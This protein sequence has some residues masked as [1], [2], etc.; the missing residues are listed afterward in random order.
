MLSLSLPLLGLLRLCFLAVVG[1]FCVVL[2]KSA[3]ADPSCGLEDWLTSLNASANSYVAALGSAS[4]HEAARQ[5]R[6]EMERYDRDRLL[7]QIRDSDLGQNE[8]ALMNYISS[9]RHL[10]DLHEGNWPEMAKRYG[11][12]PRF[13]AQANTLER[14]LTAIPCDPDAPDFLNAAAEDDQSFMARLSGGVDEMISLLTPKEEEEPAPVDPTNFDEFRPHPPAPR[15]KS[16]VALSPSGNVAFAL[17]I[18]TFITAITS[19]VWM[20]YGIVQRRAIRYPCSLPVIIFDGIAPVIGEFLDI[21]QIGAKIE[22]DLT[23]PL[24]QKIKLTCGP[25]ERKARVIWRNNHFVGVKFDRSLSELEM[26]SLLGPYAA[27]IS[28]EREEARQMGL[29]IPLSSYAPASFKPALTPPEENLDDIEAAPSDRDTSEQ[30][31]PDAAA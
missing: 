28:A 17:G 4:E 18:F 23:L 2:P 6:T 26:R 8:K 30:E 12:D 29:D 3:K 11:S 16:T 9:R 31:P 15:E 13:G 20:R 5:F 19:W 7:K 14:Y 27:Q 25:V 22:S 24:R 1:L 10:L 21:S